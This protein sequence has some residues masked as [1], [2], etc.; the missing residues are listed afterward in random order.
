M[1]WE[2]TTKTR[3]AVVGES[4][5]VEVNKWVRWFKPI[6]SHSTCQPV[7][8]VGDFTASIVSLAV[9]TENA[10]VETGKTCDKLSG[11]PLPCASVI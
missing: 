1:I 6:R 2:K 10:K 9:H 5:P 3:A 7:L 11:F 4:F 8:A